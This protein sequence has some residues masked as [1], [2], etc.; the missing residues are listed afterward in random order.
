MSMI[1]KLF[2]LE[3]H[4][5]TVRTEVIAGVT[6]FLAMAYIVVVN[7]TILVDAGMPFPGV[8]FATVL[9]CAFSSMAMGLHA[10]LP[11]GV[12]PGMGINAFFTYT[13]VVGMKI[14][15]ET[16]LGAVFI[17]GLI[18]MLL[19]VTGIRTEIVRAI[20]H[21]LRRGLAAGIGVFLSFIGFKSINFIV[22][23][24]AT[25]VGPGQ[26]T[27][28][29][30]LFVIGL[31]LAA[32]LVIR[33]VRGAFTISILLISGL[34][35][36]V[37]AV[38]VAMGWIPEPLVNTPERVFAMPDL[39]VFFKLDIVGALKIGMILPIFALFFVDM[40]DSIGTFV[41]VA[42]VAG[43]V[44][45]KGEPIN[46]GQALLMDGFSTTISGLFGSSSG[47]VYVE[48][49]AGI[50][51][52]G[53]TGLTAVVTGLLFLPFMLL[54][55]L[56]SLVPAVATAPVLVLVG[57]YMTEPLM[58]INWK[59]FEEA[60]PAFMSFALIPLTFSITE[61]VI[62]GFLTYTLIKVCLGKSRDVHWMIYVTDVFAVLSLVSPR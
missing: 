38:G 33:K 7:P 25:I 61:G 36:A 40:F 58:D 27:V 45:D 22:S 20:P 13:L 9:V 56:L 53:R 30:A 54:S 24:P 31:I 23:N 29:V 51:E 28:I 21:S 37:S 18:F 17:S 57:I 48:S 55:P 35:L 34:A 2:R 41:G 19:S 60:V 46:I 39:S 59:D 8:L 26:M 50:K 43:L 4:G 5:T 12:A 14:P 42:E 16:A 10:N 11:Y 1:Q 32:T 47:T 49:A 6:T 44:D 15:W 3:E 62:W 52:G